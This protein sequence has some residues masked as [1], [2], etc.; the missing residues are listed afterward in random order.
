[1]AWK[2]LRS[3]TPWI[4]RLPSEYLARNLRFTTQPF[5]ESQPPRAVDEIVKW[6]HGAKTLLYSSDFPHWDFDPPKSIPA[7][8]SPPLRRR[9]L[10]ENALASYPKLAELAEA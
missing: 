1:M 2:E 8:F 4:K 3:Q 5:E 7:R 9:I 6:M 10:A